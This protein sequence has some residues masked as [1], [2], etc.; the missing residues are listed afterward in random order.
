MRAGSVTGRASVSAISVEA[1]RRA[2][3]S[4]LSLLGVLSP[5]KRDK[6]LR[7]ELAPEALRFQEVT[8]SA[9]DVSS[10]RPAILSLCEDRLKGQ[11]SSA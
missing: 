10:T 4:V 5:S 7:H 1:A 3:S 11:N 8:R 6:T 2:K 9:I